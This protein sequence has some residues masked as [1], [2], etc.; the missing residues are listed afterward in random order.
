MK[1]LFVSSG[2]TENGISPIIKNQG[3]SLKKQ[4]IELKYFTIKGRGI[5]GYF[6]SIFRLHKHLKNN[7]YDIIHAHY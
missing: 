3:E 6:K 4:D 2:N 1:I 7:S 5:R